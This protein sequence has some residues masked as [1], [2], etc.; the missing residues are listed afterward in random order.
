MIY[1]ELDEP[2]G[3]FPAE[4]WKE[5][6]RADEDEEET[7]GEGNIR[8][9]RRSYRLTADDNISF[10]RRNADDRRYWLRNDERTKKTRTVHDEGGT[11]WHPI[12]DIIPGN[13]LCTSSTEKRS[14]IIGK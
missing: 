13:R 2:R 14:R 3:K 5:T 11:S 1:E 7:K 8:I 6:G 12:A 9:W 4:K 10:R